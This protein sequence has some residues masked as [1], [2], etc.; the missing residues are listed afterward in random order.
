VIADLHTKCSNARSDRRPDFAEADDTS[1]LAA[2]A[3]A[4]R[5]RTI[6]PLLRTRESI[7]LANPAHYS[8]KKAQRKIGH[9]LGDGLGRIAHDDSM[10]SR[11]IQINGVTAITETCDNLEVGQRFE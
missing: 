4:E 9:R 7:A 1:A 2:D 10:P 5:W 6:E 3:R 11:R 8:D